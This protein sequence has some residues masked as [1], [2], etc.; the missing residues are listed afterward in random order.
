MSMRPKKK[1]VC[2]PFSDQPKILENLGCFSFLFFFFFLSFFFVDAIR[3]PLSPNAR[4][5][6]GV[7]RRQGEPSA[8]GRQ[9]YLA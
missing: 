2:L 7:Q 5:V 1:D 3:L 9:Q 4:R 6:A 8:K